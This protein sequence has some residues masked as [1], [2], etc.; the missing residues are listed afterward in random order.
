MFHLLV[1]A[2][3]PMLVSA[4]GFLPRIHFPIENRTHNT[5]RIEALGFNKTSYGTTPRIEPVF[6]LYRS[7]F[8]PCPQL[9]TLTWLYLGLPCG[10][11]I[12]DTPIQCGWEGPRGDAIDG[13]ESVNGWSSCQEYFRAVEGEREMSE[14]AKKWLKWRIL[15]FKES[16]GTKSADLVPL[17]PEVPFRSLR[18]E[19]VNG[20]PIKQYVVNDGV[21]A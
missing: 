12:P 17:R 5:W 13:K 11:I 19:I 21:S 4:Q 15:D 1:I 20:I 8:S 3:T 2:I 14:Q 18:L 9:E 10:W 6:F 7:Y 16:R